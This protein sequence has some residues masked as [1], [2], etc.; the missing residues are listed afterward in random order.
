M[1]SFMNGENETGATG[2]S[3]EERKIAGGFIELAYEPLLELARNRRRRAGFHDTMMTEDI[4]HESFMKLSGKTVWQSPEQFLRT[5]SLA[6]RQV[7]VDHA[8]RNLTAKRGEGK[9]AVEYIDDETVLP[10]FSETPEQIL[11]VNDLL[12]Q[13]EAAQPRLA[14]IVDA[15]YFSGM[16][17]AETASAFGLSERTVRRDW[18]AARNWLAKMMQAADS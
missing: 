3:D 4:L 9:S 5:A 16:T 7:I 17:E 2:Y 11:I 1:D 6:I 10:E 18:Q 15:R 12:Q 13:L 14:K 8:R